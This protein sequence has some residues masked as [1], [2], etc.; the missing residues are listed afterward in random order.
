MAHSDN[1]TTEEE[2]EEDAGWEKSAASLIISEKTEKMKTLPIGMGLINK[3]LFERNPGQKKWLDSIIPQRLSSKLKLGLL[4]AS[5]II[6][7]Q[8]C[9]SLLAAFVPLMVDASL[10]NG[11]DTINA[12][13]NN[14]HKHFS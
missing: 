2:K 14:T 5:H 3:V 13:A 6:V 12:A 8:A 1:K 7:M 9:V 11:E 10:L 4:N